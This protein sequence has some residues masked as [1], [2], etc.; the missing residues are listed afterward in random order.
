[1]LL[2]GFSQAFAHKFGWGDY[3]VFEARINSTFTEPDW[4]AIYLA[5]L[6]ALE[7]WLL[8][9]A[10]SCKSKSN[11][12]SFEAIRIAK[13]VAFVDVFLIFVLLLVSA[14][15]SGWLG[16]IVVVIAYIVALFFSRKKSK[17]ILIQAASL[18][19][20]LLA[21][22]FVVDKTELST[23]HFGNRAASSVSGMQKI[24]VSCQSNDFVPKNIESVDE[25]KRYGCKHIDLEDIAVERREGN[26]IKEVYRPDP[27]VNIRKEIYATTWSEIKKHPIFGQ[28]LGSSALI[29]GTD[30]QGSGLNAS[31][32]FLV[33]WLA[34]GIFGLAIIVIVLLVPPVKSK[35]ELFK[36]W[37]GK[38]LETQKLLE[39]SFIFITA[40]AIIIPNLFN[41]GLFLGF[42]WIWLAAIIGLVNGSCE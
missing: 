26:I 22:L 33:S 18:V 31:N 19:L 1:M 10:H 23:F 29:L 21:A 16:A 27:N 3:E 12:C 38:K 9:A 28:G 5:L 11:I 35:L 7:L 13:W 14:S 8:F 20:V 15:R 34:M 30:A 39:Y 36:A 2:F 24:T 41:S 6:L 25:L 4:F 42:M 17:F 40:G 32:I 37:R